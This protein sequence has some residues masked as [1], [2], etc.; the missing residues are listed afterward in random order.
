[1]LVGR[2]PLL[3]A[4]TEPEGENMERN[5]AAEQPQT[6]ARLER[7]LREWAAA[8]QPPGLSED[9]SAFSRRHEQ[10]FAEHRITPEAPAARRRVEPGDGSIQAEPAGPPATERPR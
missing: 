4:L 10:L 9:A 6:V 2:P 3:F 5:L 7:R 8:L 1:M